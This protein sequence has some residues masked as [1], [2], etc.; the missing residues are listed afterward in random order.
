MG[1]RGVVMSATEARTKLDLLIRGRL[2]VVKVHPEIA[3]AIDDLVEAVRA[4]RCTRLEV[5]NAELR[6][7]CRRA[8]SVVYGEGPDDLAAELED[9]AEGREERT[10]DA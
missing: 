10:D 8:A 5:E 4:E 1:R 2:R 7:L 9:A 6:K 3:A